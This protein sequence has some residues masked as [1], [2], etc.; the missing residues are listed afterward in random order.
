MITVQV[1]TDR[2]I[3]R[4]DRDAAHGAIAHLDRHVDRPRLSA[5]LTVD[6]PLA[7]FDAIDELFFGD[8]GDDGRGKLLSLRH[9][10]DDGLVE[11]A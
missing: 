10:G 9:D 6:V 1:R 5:R 2:R 11:A 8:A 4:R 7:T 3:P